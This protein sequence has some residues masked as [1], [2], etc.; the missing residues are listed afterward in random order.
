[1]TAVLEPIQTKGLT[2]ADVDELTRTT[3]DNMLRELVPLTAKA[4]GKPMSVP[5]TNGHAKAVKASG[6]DT[7][8]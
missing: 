6:A 8:A 1:M 2:S 3:H 5:A 7:T 4:Q